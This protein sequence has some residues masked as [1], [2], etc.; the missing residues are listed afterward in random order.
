MARVAPAPALNAKVYR[1]FAI[2]TL[3]ITASLALF[4]DGEK[5]EAIADRVAEREAKTELQRAD[6]ERQ[7]GKT[8]RK[9]FEF[10]TDRAPTGSFGTDEMIGAPTS[11]VGGGSQASAPP[12]PSD[13]ALP[14]APAAA[15]GDAPRIPPPPPGMSAEEYRKRLEEARKKAAQPADKMS[16]REVEQMI[17][18]SRRRTGEAEV[19]ESWF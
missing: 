18:A 17:E 7:G 1:H 8:G 6:H 5:R 9:G 16:P 13:M 14:V 10:R 4:A 15:S 11:Y 2:V 19:E 12:M 3:V